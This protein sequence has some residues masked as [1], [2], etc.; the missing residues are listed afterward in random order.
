MTMFIVTFLTLV[1]FFIFMSLGVIFSN[2]RIQGS[3]GGLGK[4]MGEDCDYCDKKDECEHSET[5]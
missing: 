3:C 2:K 1:L 4:V 5:A